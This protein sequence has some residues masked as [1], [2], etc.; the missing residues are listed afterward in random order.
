MGTTP[1]Y[2]FPFPEGN[3]PA[4]PPDHFAALAL[5]VENTL[6]QVPVSYPVPPTYA[7]QT[8]KTVTSTS[9]EAAVPG[10]P[11][12]ALKN[13][14]TTAKLLVRVQFSGLAQVANA[15]SGYTSLNASI[16]K[17]AASTAP[18]IVSRVKDY[19]E[20]HP[21]YRMWRGFI[22]EYLCYIGAGAT[23]TFQGNGWKAGSGGT[24]ITNGRM[25]ITPIAYT[26]AALPVYPAVADAEVIIP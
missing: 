14:S 18:T 1:I 12:I 3:S 19:V 16:S 13:P 6:K 5:A 15:A 7:T 21:G 26:T 10:L 23:C 8:A 24:V 11:T 25:A 22:A 9:A 17:T 4:Y 2:T 20:S